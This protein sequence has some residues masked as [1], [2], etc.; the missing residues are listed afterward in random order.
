VGEFKKQALVANARIEEL[1]RRVKVPAS[2][3]S[4]NTRHDPLTLA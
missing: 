1:E 4:F 3:N 2:S